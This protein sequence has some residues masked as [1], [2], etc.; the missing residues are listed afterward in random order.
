MSIEDDACDDVEEMWLKLK[1]ST[2]AGNSQSLWVDEL[3][4]DVERSGSAINLRDR[5]GERRE[6][7]E[8]G[9]CLK[10]LCGHLLLSNANAQ[11][12]HAADEEPDKNSDPLF[13]RFLL[14]K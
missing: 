3:F 10:A 13:C 12:S 8:H 7:N 6:T 5:E 11:P 14:S 1:E 2:S 4:G 9:A